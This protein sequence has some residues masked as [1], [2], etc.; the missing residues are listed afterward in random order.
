MRQHLLLY[1]NL[2]YEKHWAIKKE[3]YTHTSTTLSQ[4]LERQKRKSGE[5]RTQIFKDFDLLSI[6]NLNCW[7]TVAMYALKAS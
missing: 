7:S 6:W 2:E 4:K 1:N 3:T 5:I